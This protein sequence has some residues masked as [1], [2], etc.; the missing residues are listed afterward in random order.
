VSWV[1]DAVFYH[2]YPLGALGA[3]AR[4]DFAGPPAP[5]LEGLHGWLAEVLDLGATAVYLGPVFESTAHGYDTADYFT[6]DRRLGDN[7]ALARW[8]E[9]LHRRG[10]RLVLDGVFHHVGR[11][12][13]AFRDVLA[14]GAASQF[15]DW[16]FLDFDG[17]STYGDP[18]DYRGWNGHHSL[19]KLNTSHP[20]LRE[21]LFA[22]V[23]QWV[24]AFGIDGLR[25]DAADHLDRGFQRD[26]AAFCRSLRPDF[27]LMGEVVHGDYRQWANPAAL[28]SVTN[29]ELYK[30]LYSSHNDRN[31]FEVAYALNRQSGEGGLYRDLALYTFADNHDVDRVASRLTNPA[32]LDPLYAL[33][34]TAPGVPSIYY[35]SEWGIQGCKAHGSDRPLRPAL[36]P[37]GLRGVAPHPVLRD[38]IKRLVRLRHAHPA[39][40]RGAYRQLHV[41]HEQLAYLRATAEE[42]VV[43]AVNAADRAT[44]VRLSLPGT[45][46]GWLVDELNPGDTFAL[47]D[48]RATVLLPP[49][50]ARILRLERGG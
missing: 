26:L 37:D 43:V 28:D 2:L 45:A 49:C 38:A 39:L 35:G 5:R 9:A 21:H 4:N 41:A 22:A 11:D 7:A 33:L 31:Y 44:E 14:H 42:P 32:H 40:R 30:A 10:L 47:E 8:S 16:F 19:V 20:Q 25:L 6:V 50:G 23:H 48:G 46:R 36:D 1:R 17:R 3:P 34:F 15:R 13:W 29:Y 12:F 24:Q 18:F 27:W